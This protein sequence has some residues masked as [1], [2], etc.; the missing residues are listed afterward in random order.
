MQRY[1]LRTL[2]IKNSLNRRERVMI[3][4]CCGKYKLDDN[5]PF[6]VNDIV[7]EPYTGNPC[8]KFSNFCGPVKNHTIRDLKSL[9]VRA[10]KTMGSA[11]KCAHNGYKKGDPMLCCQCRDSITKLIKEIEEC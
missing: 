6:Q 2:A 10:G 1:Q 5:I 8:D 9:L 3:R 7:H 4:C 11:M